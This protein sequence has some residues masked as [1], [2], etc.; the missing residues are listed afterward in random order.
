MEIEVFKV[1]HVGYVKI[2]E[3][4]IKGRKSDVLYGH[5]IAECYSEC[6]KVEEYALPI[7]VDATISIEMVSNIITIDRCEKTEFKQR[8]KNS[9]NIYC[10]GILKKIHDLDSIICDVGYFSDI[11]VLM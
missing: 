5:M 6:M 1:W 11:C 2:I 8:I 9:P 3:F 4:N 10:R 7:K